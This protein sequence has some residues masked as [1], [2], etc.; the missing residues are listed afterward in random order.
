[1]PPDQRLEDAAGTADPRLAPVRRPSRSTA[2]NAAGTSATSW[3]RTAQVSTIA[4]STSPSF[5]LDGVVSA[6]SR[7][8]T[9][10]RKSG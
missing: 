8:Q 2:V 7:S 4:P 9:V 5:S 10:T 6:R 3:I 1:M